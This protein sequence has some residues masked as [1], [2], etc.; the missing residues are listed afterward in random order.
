MVNFNRRTIKWKKKLPYISKQIVSFSAILDIEIIWKFNHVNIQRM[1][2][3]YKPFPGCWI[4]LPSSRSAIL[5]PHS[6]L[7]KQ[8]EHLDHIVK[9]FLFLKYGRQRRSKKYREE[10]MGCWGVEKSDKKKNL[11]KNDREGWRGSAVS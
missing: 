9:I 7:K 6:L 4:F 10:M 11:N 2:R 5:D 1:R 3:I 8:R